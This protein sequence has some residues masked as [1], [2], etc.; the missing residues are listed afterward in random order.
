VTAAALDRLLA[1]LIVALAA[2]GLVSLRMGSPDDSWLFALHGVLASVLALSVAWKLARSLPR[3]VRARRWRAIAIALLLSFATVASIVGGFAWVAGGRLLS[4]GSWTILTMHAWIGL[5]LIPITAVHLA[6]R[7]WRLLVPRPR[8]RATA[9]TRL[10]VATAARG[11]VG[12]RRILVAGAVG[13]A[14][15]GLFGAADLAD[16]LT[17]GVRRFTGSRWL[18]AGGLPP[19]TTFLG[20]AAPAI[21]AMTWRLR[22]HRATETGAAL[23]AD[24]LAALGLVERTAVLDCTSG[25]ALETTW[26]GVPLTAVLAAAGMDTHDRPVVIRAVTGWSTTLAPGEIERALLA[27][28]VAG[29]PLPVVNGA[30]CRLV[31]PDRRG[32]DWVKWVAEVEIA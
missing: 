22:V 5:V 17:G 32:L 29:E 10:P 26:H 14:S 23:S 4:I 19:D 20:E 12:R 31:M 1:V 16:R 28:G 24:E 7:R 15:L 6:P 11:P 13:A 8:P 9:A 18:P 27:F 2:T 3:A 25:W 30:P 21:D